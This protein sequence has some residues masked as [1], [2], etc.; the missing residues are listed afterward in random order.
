[1]NDKNHTSIFKHQQSK[2]GK[3]PLNLG[4]IGKIYTIFFPRFSGKNLGKINNIFC[5]K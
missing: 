5:L 3:G 1:M 2:L 4:K